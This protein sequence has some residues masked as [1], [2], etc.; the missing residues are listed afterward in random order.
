M[1]NMV[2]DAIDPEWRD[3]V[4]DWERNNNLVIVAPWQDKDG[5][6]VRFLIPVSWGIKPIKTIADYAIDLMQGHD[7]GE[8]KDIAAGIAGATLDAY[9]PVGGSNLRQAVTPTF[10]DVPGDVWYNQAWY[11]KPIKPDSPFYP[12]LPEH[13][14]YFRSLKETA[15]G[16]FAINTTNYLAEKGGIRI[17]PNVLK[18]VIEQ[19]GGGTA[20][21]AVQTF[22]TAL[23]VAKPE[24][25]TVN[26]IPVVNRF[27]KVTPQDVVE[28]WKESKRLDPCPLLLRARRYFRPILGVYRFFR[29]RVSFVHYRLVAGFLRRVLGMDA[30]ATRVAMG[31]H[32]RWK[33]VHRFSLATAI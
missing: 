8:A 16:R 30:A 4:P 1:Q 17:S 27:F 33:R 12:N 31:A 15:P 14:K 24:A 3:K 13:K 5:D 9:N 10:L 19:G 20:R 21:F 2:N 6:Y 28:R 29:R 26:E 7:R 22:N 25:T 18:Y 32:H 11:G 23:N